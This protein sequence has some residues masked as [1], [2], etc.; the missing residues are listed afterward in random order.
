MKLFLRTDGVD[1]VVHEGDQLIIGSQG[2][3][4]VNGLPDVEEDD[5]YLEIINAVNSIPQETSETP[6]MK[7]SAVNSIIQP[8]PDS[9]TID[10]VNSILDMEQEP[11]EEQSEQAFMDNTSHC[12]E[13]V[14]EP[15]EEENGWRHEVIIENE[16][17]L[18]PSKPITND[19]VVSEQ[20]NDTIMYQEDG[21]ATDSATETV[22]EVIPTVL[23]TEQPP[24]AM[25]TDDKN[26]TVLIINTEQIVQPPSNI[27]PEIQKPKEEPQIKSNPPLLESEEVKIRH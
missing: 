25:D 17:M 1:L 26:Q 22:D 2:T 5:P 15:S 14:G 16:M 18:Q 11:E 9:E 21:S 8:L 4:E 19:A 20:S 7:N 10:A 6:F 12:Y 24:Q 3:V 27:V 13:L 23:V